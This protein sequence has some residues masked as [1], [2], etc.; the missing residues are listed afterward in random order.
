KIAY[1]DRFS[2]INSSLNAVFGNPDLAY[3]AA[4]FGKAGNPDLKWETTTQTDIGLEFT[5]F[6]RKL[7]GEIDYFNRLTEDILVELATPGHLGN[8]QGQRVRFNAAS[9][10]NSG[11]E[12]SLKWDDNVGDLGYSIGF[13]GNPVHNEV[14]AI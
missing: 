14:R 6:N 4:T 5:L 12:L 2:R 7:S 11:F 3:I 9:I 1:F 13:I 8:G 10:E